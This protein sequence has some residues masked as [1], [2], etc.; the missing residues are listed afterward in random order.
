MRNTISSKGHAR[1]A[2]MLGT[3]LALTVGVSL[4]VGQVE[5]RVVPQDDAIGGYEKASGNDGT[6]QSRHTLPPARI[7]VG[8]DGGRDRHTETYAISHRPGFDPF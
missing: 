1:L 8:P 4:A 7:K 2:W 6:A 5:G 3:V